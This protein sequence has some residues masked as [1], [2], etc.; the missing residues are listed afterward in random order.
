LSVGFTGSL[1]VTTKLPLLLPLAEGEKVTASCAVWPGVRVAGV[2]MPLIV[3]SAPVR[4]SSEIV[5]L[6]DPVFVST[7]LFV[8]FRP[9]EML[10]KLMVVGFTASC[11]CELVPVADKLTVTGV[12]PVSP[13]TVKVA[14]SAPAM[15][16]ATEIAT[17]D[18]CPTAKAVGVV[19]PVTVKC[20]SETASFTMFTEIFPVFVTE[21]VCVVCLPIATWPKFTFTGFNWNE[22]VV[23]EPCLALDTKPAQPATNE[24]IGVTD[25]IRNKLKT[26]CFSFLR[27]VLLWVLTVRA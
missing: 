16:G 20:A 5:K 3:K 6:A 17:F 26:V 2:V 8:V 1:L 9:V 7:K 11:G 14:V 22:A 4:A 12:L 10:P 23:D 21:I 13:C 18:D 27:P 15:V 24:K 25:A 19:I